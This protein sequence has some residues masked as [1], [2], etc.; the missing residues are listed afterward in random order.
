MPRMPNG[1]CVVSESGIRTRTDM[2]RLQAGGVKAVLIGETFMRA[3]DI[4]AKM[5]EM[6][7]S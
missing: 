4:G 5:D 2:E 7:L 1:A 3:A 6:M